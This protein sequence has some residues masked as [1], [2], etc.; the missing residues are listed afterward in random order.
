MASRSAVVIPGV[1][2]ALSFSRVRPTT[3]PASRISA[4]SSS[5]LIWINA[6]SL[7]EGPERGER[8]L[9]HVVDGT[10]GV[11]AHQDAG[12]GVVAHQRRRLFVVDLESVPDRLRLVVVALEQLAAADVTD[13]LRRR[14]VGGPMP[15]VP[16]TPARTPSPQ[17]PGPPA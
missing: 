9:R 5:V 3:S 8:S 15:E 2:A 12:L 1:T 7:P 13:T 17:G 14:R 10:H 11:D 16:T 6:L 4:I